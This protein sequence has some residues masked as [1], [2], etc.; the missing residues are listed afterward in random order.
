[1]ILSTDSKIL[2]LK[3]QIVIFFAKRIEKVCKYLGIT[4]FNILI[5]FNDLSF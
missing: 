2:I 3:N 4:N 5:N 1:M